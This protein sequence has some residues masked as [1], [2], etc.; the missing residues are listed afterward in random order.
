MP[1]NLKSAET[2]DVEDLDELDNLA[3]LP[4]TPPA[5]T[6]DG[7]MVADLDLLDDQEGTDGSEQAQDDASVNDD[8]DH[9]ADLARVD[10]P[11]E[12]AADEPEADVVEEEAAEEGADEEANDDEPAE[13][14]TDD[15]AAEL[16][17]IQTAI[18]DWREEQ[19]IPASPDAYEIPETAAMLA[20]A[21]MLQGVLQL[22]HD[23]NTPQTLVSEL[24]EQY[25]EETGKVVAGRTDRDLRDAVTIKTSLE[26]SWGESYPGDIKLIKT[27]LEDAKALPKGTREAILSARLPN[28][29]RLANN[30]PTLQFLRDAAKAKYGDAKAQRVQRITDIQKVMGTDEYWRNGLD[31]EYLELTTAEN[32]G[33]PAEPLTHDESRLREIEKVMNEDMNEY[34]RQGLDAEYA[35][36]I[37]RKQQQGRRRA[38]R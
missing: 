15:E 2:V 32:A 20:E 35:E 28:G 7:P 16:E 18:A 37:A 10:E 30:L 24:L 12:D 29:Q 17:Q 4:P 11:I 5:A 21:P 19:G 1:D 6:T 22:L 26:Q 23:H 31:K 33:V 36:L 27:L 38:M 14:L 25:A 3:Q 13:E 8:A 9:D 34:Y